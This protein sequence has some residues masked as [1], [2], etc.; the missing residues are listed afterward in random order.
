ME[1]SEGQGNKIRAA[2]KAKKSFTW[3]SDFS[4]MVRVDDPRLSSPLLE[5]WMKRLVI[6]NPRSRHG[7]AGRLFEALRPDWERKLGSFELYR[8]RCP[9]DATEKVRSV[10][11]KGDVD[12]ILVAG[13]DGSVNEACNGYWDKGVI[14]NPGVPLG[15]INLGTGGDFFRTVTGCSG[16]YEAALIGN[17]FRLVD[18]AK[19]TPGDGIPRYF[20]NIS[21][22]GMAGEMLRNLKAS[23][24][25]NGASAYFFHTLKTLLGYRAK[26][27]RVNL[28]DETGVPRSL[29]VDM[30]NLFVCNGRYS[31]GGMQWAPAAQLDDGLLRLTVISGSRKWPLIIQSRKLYRGEVGTFPGAITFTVSGV[32]VRLAQT[33]SL[34]TDGEVVE[35]RPESAHEFH[36]EVLPRVF[37]L[38]L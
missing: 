5:T 10:L 37:P 25:Q 28:V 26:R 34:E 29:E 33:V 22:V 7:K 17:C 15:I 19:V 1:Q 23:F 13:G 32:T 8:T 3:K 9:G 30:L 21:S 27:V 16:D 24:F 20:L 4:N 14:T 12:Q 36:Y 11:Q 18:A 38:V 2:K 6:L 31:G 35:L